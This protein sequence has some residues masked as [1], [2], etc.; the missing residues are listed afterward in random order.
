M[1]C[2]IPEG[3]VSTTEAAARTKCKGGTRKISKL[4]ECGNIK[5]AQINGKNYVYF[6]DVI[7]YLA[8]HPEKKTNTVWG[9]VDE[10]KQKAFFKYTDMTINILSPMT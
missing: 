2:N 7:Q 5:F 4:I 3:Y 10:M 8:N 9:E 1:K 6:H